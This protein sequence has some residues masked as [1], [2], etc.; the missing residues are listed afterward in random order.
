MSTKSQDIQTQLR[1][2][3]K[4]NDLR[5]TEQR[6]AV[7]TTLHLHR[8]PMTHDEFMRVLPGGAYD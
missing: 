1:A 7:L 2:L 6:L 5:V 4:S 8:T 3:V